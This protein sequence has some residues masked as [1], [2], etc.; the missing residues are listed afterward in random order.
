MPHDSDKAI[1]AKC[2]NEAM[3]G[4]FISGVKASVVAA[5]AYYLAWKYSALFRTSF[6]AQARTAL[7]AMPVFYTA[8]LNVEQHMHACMHSS[9]PE[10]VLAD[11]D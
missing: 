11:E 1:R 5:G 6:T 9:G 10:Y 8:Y 7:I 3:L 2:L 4:G